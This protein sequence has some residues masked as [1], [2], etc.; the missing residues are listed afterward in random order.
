MQILSSTDTSDPGVFS[1]TTELAPSSDSKE[2]LTL[3]TSWFSECLQSHLSCT[4]AFPKT[5]YLPTRLVEIEYSKG[6]EAKIRLCKGNGMSSGTCYATLSHCWGSVMPFRLTNE[7]FHACFENIPFA[8]ISKAFQ[9]AI[10]FAYH[11]NLRY[12]WIDSLCEISDS[13]IL[14]NKAKR[15]RYH[16]RFG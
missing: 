16:S 13:L 6:G 1:Y 5:S 12:I 10:C 7:N 9:Q 14:P 11:L 3:A 2:S 4:T 15:A 8:A